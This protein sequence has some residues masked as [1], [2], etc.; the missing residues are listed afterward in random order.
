[1]TLPTFIDAVTLSAE[2]YVN[3]GSSNEKSFYSLNASKYVQSNP[4]DASSGNLIT[5]QAQLGVK[6]LGSTPQSK[7][8]FSGSD[9]IMVIS[10]GSDFTFQVSTQNGIPPTI[11]SNIPTPPVHLST[12][13]WS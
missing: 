7:T 4:L 12:M 11:D 2:L 5:A 9:S 6:A 8:F 3:Q 1:M 10:D 13:Y